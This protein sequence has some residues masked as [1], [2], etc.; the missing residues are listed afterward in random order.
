VTKALAV[1][2]RFEK[3]CKSARCF[4]EASACAKASQK[5]QMA[6]DAWNRTRQAIISRAM[7]RQQMQRAA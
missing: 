4:K 5:C 3:C 7:Q 1:C 6:L 2:Q